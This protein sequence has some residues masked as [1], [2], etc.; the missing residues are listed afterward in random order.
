MK[1][2]DPDHATR[3]LHQAIEAGNFPSRTL[4][5]QILSQE[6]AAATAK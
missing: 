5:M 1:G 2:K 4:E 6:Q 3:D